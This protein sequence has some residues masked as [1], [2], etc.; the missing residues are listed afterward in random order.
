MNV[1]QDTTLCDCDVSEK[2]VQFLIVADGELEM[3]RDDTGLLVVTGGVTSQLE[4]FGRKVLKD[5]SEVDG[6]TW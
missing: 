3:T 5:S 4:D 1:W 2:L 6:G